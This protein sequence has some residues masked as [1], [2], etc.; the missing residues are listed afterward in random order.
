[1]KIEQAC[2][3]MSAAHEYSHETE[4]EVTRSFHM[5]LAEASQAETAAARESEEEIR[6]LLILQKLVAR[7]L[8][9]ISGKPGSPAD[10][11]GDLQK[12]LSMER[13]DT[14]TGNARTV[15]MEWSITLTESVREHESTNFAAAGQVRTAD[16]RTLDFTLQLGMCRDFSCTRTEQR[17]GAAELLDPLVLNFG[18]TAAELSGKRF[19]FDL[20]ADG[21]EELIPELAGGCAWLAFDRNADGR[22]NDGSE[23]F[24]VFSGN[25]FADL[26]RFDE[27]G[28]RW[29]D[30]ADSV[31]ASLCLWSRDEYDRDVLV[32]LHD[33]G[34]GAIC[35]DSTQTP[36][37]L[38]DDDNARL[39][40][41]RASGI[42]LREDGSV[43]TVQQIDLSI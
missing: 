11:L 13:S 5:V 26:A 1:M 33:K 19:A 23:L 3:A 22:I 40:Y 7:L 17:F 14:K 10:G 30:E 41:I 18:G 27:D 38:T 6:L 16:G 12:L 24:G 29:L 2:V 8:E 25:G 34:I 43:G 42:Y 32:P 15:R 9:L 20:D 39:G 35:L 36:F 31:F 28:N 4:I 21:I 37:A